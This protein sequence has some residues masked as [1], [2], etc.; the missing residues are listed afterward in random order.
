M[1]PH[2]LYQKVVLNR[3][4]FKVKPPSAAVV[5]AGGNPIGFSAD[6]LMMMSRELLGSLERGEQ[7]GE[8]LMS[9]L[10]CRSHPL[11]SL[12][13]E[14]AQ[15]IY[16]MYRTKENG[17][18]I[19]NVL[20]KCFELP[21]LVD[22]VRSF[23]YLLSSDLL[24][25]YLKVPPHVDL[26]VDECENAV[27]SAVFS[28]VSFVLFDMY[29]I[30]NEEKNLKIERAIKALQKLSLSDRMSICGIDKS[31]W[32]SLQNAISNEINIKAIDLNPVAELTPFHCKCFI[33][34]IHS[35]ICIFIIEIMKFTSYFFFLC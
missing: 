26:P 31:L 27:H 25:I 24:K 1:I 15:Y 33:C 29:N 14:F 28:A 35:F 13:C 22:D 11:G 20:Q 16:L 2:E 9:I 8:K 12:I 19:F 10:Q 30:K 23:V 7:I 18:E 5:A 4:S 17:K 21:N 6:Q 3:C 34:C 32:T